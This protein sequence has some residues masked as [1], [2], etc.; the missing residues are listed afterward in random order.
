MTRGEIWLAEVGTKTRPV[1]VLTRSEVI[2]VR[3]LVTV[4]EITTSVRGIATEVSFDRAAA[5]LDRTS[6]IN[7][8]GLQTISRSSL[9]RRVGAVPETTMVDICRAV[10]YAISC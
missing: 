3:H 10:Q 8:D 4:A 2:N 5:S 1:V 6:V 7:C 9:T